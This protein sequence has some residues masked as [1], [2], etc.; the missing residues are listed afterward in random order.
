MFAQC[1]GKMETQANKFFTFLGYFTFSLIVGTMLL[2]L[3]SRVIL[4]EY[5]RLATALW[6]TLLPIILPIPGS[7]G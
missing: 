7:H 1:W 4:P 3:A 2:V 6:P 5:H